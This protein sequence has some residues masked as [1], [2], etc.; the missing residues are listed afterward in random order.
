MKRVGD[1]LSG[2]TGVRARSAARG[3]RRKKNR[4]ECGGES[5]R[6]HTAALAVRDS[7]A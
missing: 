2:S 1:L 6:G 7:C 4:H 5:P 3:N